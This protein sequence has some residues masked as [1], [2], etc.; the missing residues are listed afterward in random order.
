[1][2]GARGL[3]TVKSAVVGII[4][5]DAGSTEYN[6]RLIV[7][8]EDHPR[9]CGEHP[10]N[11]QTNDPLAA[12]GIIPA[13]AGSTLIRYNEKPARQDHPRGCGEHGHPMLC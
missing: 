3:R 1:M 4:P 6:D 12:G 9:G 13:D 7:A 2:R 8:H 5:A 11:I 10:I